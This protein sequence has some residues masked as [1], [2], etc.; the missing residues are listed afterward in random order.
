MIFVRKLGEDEH[1][2][3]RRMTRQAIG[4]V[5]LRAH[6]ILLSAQHAPSGSPRS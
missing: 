2:E 1:Q 5:G 3:L 6:M 4:Q